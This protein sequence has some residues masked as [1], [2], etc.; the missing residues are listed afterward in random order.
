MP[1]PAFSRVRLIKALPDLNLPKGALGK[2]KRVIP[3]DE[4]QYVT[5]FDLLPGLVIDLYSADLDPRSP[6]H[7]A[8]IIYGSGADVRRIDCGNEEPAE[9]REIPEQTD[10]DGLP[11]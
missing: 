5:A 2:I 9:L 7:C 10:E 1:F 11:L 3:G 6:Q 8:E 4:T